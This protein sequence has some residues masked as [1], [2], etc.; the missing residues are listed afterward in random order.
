[1]KTQLPAQRQT[2]QSPP[3]LMRMKI[4]PLLWRVQNRIVEERQRQQ[5]VERV[6]G[7]T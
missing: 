5:P 4:L 6:L 1:M 2:G 7:Q 3:V